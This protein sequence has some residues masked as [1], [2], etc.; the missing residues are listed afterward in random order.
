ML[1]LPRTDFWERFVPP[2]QEFSAVGTYC[3][4]AS[5]RTGYLVGFFQ[6]E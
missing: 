5:F 4:T 6:A 1:Q 2:F 3:T